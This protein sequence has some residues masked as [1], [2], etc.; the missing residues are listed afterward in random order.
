[1][2]PPALFISFIFSFLTIVFY[3]DSSRTRV[4]NERDQS[5]TPSGCGDIPN[6]VSPV[7][8]SFLFIYLNRPPAA[9]GNE[10]RRQ[11]ER[12]ECDGTTRAAGCNSRG[13]TVRPLRFLFLSVLL[14]I[15][16]FYHNSSRPCA[17]TNEQ[18]RAGPSETHSG[19][20]SVRLPPF[21][22]FVFYS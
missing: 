21:L 14:L 20:G 13:S 17:T 6:P 12:V 18:D 15:I 8:F 22:S 3:H 1:M 19:G 4:T 9:D 11:R 7:Y 5:G 16:G 10:H 2:R